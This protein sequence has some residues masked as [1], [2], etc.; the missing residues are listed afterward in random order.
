[1]LA[2]IY[3]L[4]DYLFMYSSQRYCILVPFSNSIFSDYLHLFGS[5]AT[6][7]IFSDYLH[8]FGSEAT[9]SIFSDYLHLFGSEATN[10]IFSDYLH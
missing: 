1:M 9:N 5:E 8:L 2:V 7:S 4:F 3:L 10:S 6:N